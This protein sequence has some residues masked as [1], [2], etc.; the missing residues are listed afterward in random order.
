MKT[1]VL[2]EKKYNNALKRRMA[3][4]YARCVGR[5][6]TDL[7]ANRVLEV[8]TGLGYFWELAEQPRIITH[9]CDR[10]AACLRGN[11][12]LLGN[13]K[14]CADIGRL[15][16]PDNSFDLVVAIEVL[17]HCAEPEQMLKALSRVTR[18][19]LLVGV[20]WEPWFRLSLFLSGNHLRHW[21]NNP[22][23]VTHFSS[24]RFQKFLSKQGTLIHYA[25][26]F[27]WQFGIITCQP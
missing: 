26:P 4:H 17:E 3:R 6:I 14:I 27:P 8:G 11:Q 1:T 24:L 12:V 23:H 19:Y 21:G 25:R 15:P 7:P 22:N 13:R 16:F 10:N 20:P 9:G 2:E 18:N 5:A